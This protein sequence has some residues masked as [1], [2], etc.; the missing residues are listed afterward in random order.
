M[1]EECRSRF[2]LSDYAEEVFNYKFFRNFHE[3]DVSK[4]EAISFLFWCDQIAEYFLKD[5]KAGLKPLN[6]V[7]PMMDLSKS[8][9]FPVR[10]N[11]ATKLHSFWIIPHLDAN[12]KNWFMMVDVHVPSLPL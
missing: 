2:H 3:S 4:S 6:E 12:I 11:E 7:Y 10:K 5:C 1:E 8:C 9:G